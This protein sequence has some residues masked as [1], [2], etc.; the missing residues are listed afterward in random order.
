MINIIF[1]CVYIYKHIYIYIC[2]RYQEGIIFNPYRLAI[3]PCGICIGT[4]FV[5]RLVGRTVVKKMVP[6]TPSCRVQPQPS[7]RLHPTM[8]EA[9]GCILLCTILKGQ[10]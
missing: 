7:C 9:A 8:L 1:L 3:L 4:F 2:V 6:P 10:H 5:G